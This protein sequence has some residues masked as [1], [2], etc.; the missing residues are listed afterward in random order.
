MHARPSRP[1]RPMD[2][3]ASLTWR[4]ANC[5]AQSCSSRSHVFVFV[6]QS[7]CVSSSPCSYSF[8]FLVPSNQTHRFRSLCLLPAR[9]RSM[10]QQNGLITSWRAAASAFER[11][12]ISLSFR[13][14]LTWT[15]SLGLVRALDWRML[16]SIAEALSAY[17]MGIFCTGLFQCFRDSVALEASKDIRLYIFFERYKYGTSRLTWSSRKRKASISQGVFLLHI[18]FTPLPHGPCHIGAINKYS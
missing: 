18:A 8:K 11:F 3:C 14:L 5:I 16:R 10:V 4:C 9:Y 13:D 15:K 17:P 6:S 12:L 7:F 2:G 1:S